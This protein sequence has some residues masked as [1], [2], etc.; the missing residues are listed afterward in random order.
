MESTGVS[1]H[2]RFPNTEIEASG[3]GDKLLVL[4]V[5]EAISYDVKLAEEEPGPRGLRK[6]GGPPE[7]HSHVLLVEDL[8]IKRVARLCC[9]EWL[10]EAKKMSD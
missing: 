2:F 5:T 7:E 6:F 4:S 1:D 10:S 3:G 8:R 9:R